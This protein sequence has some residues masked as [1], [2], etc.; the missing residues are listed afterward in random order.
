MQLLQD[1]K[2]RSRASCTINGYNF[3]SLLSRWHP[4]YPYLRTR[5]FA[6]SH[7]CE[8]AIIWVFLFAL[9]IPLLI[10]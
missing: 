2:T 8:F 1:K 5:S 9:L 7:Y 4:D 10:H 6:S 3:T